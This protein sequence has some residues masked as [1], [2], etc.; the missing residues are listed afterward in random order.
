MLA[1]IAKLIW[2]RKQANILIITEVAITFAVIFFISA[3]ALSNYQTYHQPLGFKWQD[4]WEI[5]VNTGAEW[6]NDVD[7]DQ[8]SQLVYA[9]KKQPEIAS[10]GLT[11][12]PVFERSSMTSSREVNGQEIY[13]KANYVDQHGPK[14]WGVELIAGRWFGEQDN[15]QNYTEVMINQRFAQQAFNDSNP[16]GFEFGNSLHPE[17]KLLRIVGVF[18]DFRQMGEFSKSMPYL[19]Y[20]YQLEEGNSRGMNNINITFNTMKNASYEEDLLK[21]L[22][23]ITPNWEFTIRTWQAKRQAQIK[24]VLIPL[25][26]MAIVVAFLLIMVAMGLFGVLWQNISRRTQEIGLRRA[27]GASKLSIQLQIIGELIVLALFGIGIVS[28]LLIQLP[29][30][31]LV[32][33]LTW[34]IFWLSMSCSM[35]IMLVMVVLC[36]LYPSRTAIRIPPAHALHYE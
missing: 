24:E 13:F 23:G 34:S 36:A 22:K 9:L 33:E 18:Q 26:V 27:L 35:V 20:R 16:I 30:L 25:S 3:L 2:N 14:S 8:F 21:L 29:I 1:H 7:K 28:L 10:V 17:R 19:F 32:D 5:K 15:G 12:M 11:L 31:Q 4:T 6:N